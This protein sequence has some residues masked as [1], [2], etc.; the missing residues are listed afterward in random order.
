MA[1]DNHL[2]VKRSSSTTDFDAQL[3][4]K[5]NKL[6]LDHD[7]I[8]QNVNYAQPTDGVPLDDGVVETLLTRSIILALDVIGFKTS[9]PLALESFRMGVEEC[10]RP[11]CL[12]LSRWLY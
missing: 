7:K 11:S 5:R 10:M 12:Q 4:I 3:A 2:P 6:G 1:F 9:E 8:N